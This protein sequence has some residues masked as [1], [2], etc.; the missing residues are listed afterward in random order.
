MGEGGAGL[1]RKGR[2][3]PLHFRSPDMPRNDFFW[4]KGRRLILEYPYLTTVWLRL[5]WGG[6]R[7]S[8]GFLYS[9]T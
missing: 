1:A 2:N 8:S 7:G 3:P 9:I 4:V 6:F 5:V